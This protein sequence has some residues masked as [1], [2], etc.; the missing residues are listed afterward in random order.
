MSFNNYFNNSLNNITDSK[1]KD[2]MSYSLFSNG[3]QLRSK[4]LIEMTKA[5]GI[6]E[7]L[8]YNPAIALEMIHTYSLIHDDLPAMDNDDLR[9]GK[10]T[11]HKEF[12]EAIAIL[13]GDALLT[14]AFD[15]LVESSLSDTQKI[16]LIKLYNQYAGA[17][18]MILGQVLDMYANTSE[19]NLE[20]LKNM[21]LNKTGRLFSISFITSC[22]IANKTIDKS[23]LDKIGSDLGLAFQIQDDLF[24]V[25]K[26]TDEIG[27]NVSSDKDNNKITI[28]KF[29]NIEQANNLMNNL[30]DN[31]INNLIKLDINSDNIIKLINNIRERS[32]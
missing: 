12:D 3:K 7:T 6:D 4:I 27:K 16:Q 13:A 5:Y 2:A 15:L 19:Y 32:K 14:H 11:C 28:N 24:E 30:Y 17:N 23:I 8:A 20:Y 21:H 29:L 26:T 1:V 10:N 18:G 31:A 22:I 9:R 25:T